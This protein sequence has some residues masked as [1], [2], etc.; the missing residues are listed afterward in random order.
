MITTHTE[1]IVI[2]VQSCFKSN[3]GMSVACNIIEVMI[4]IVNNVMDTR[5]FIKLC[6]RPRRSLFLT[7]M[8]KH[9]WK[10]KG[11]PQED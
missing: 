9:L 3:K 10:A 6:F 1:L 7:I 11:V 2:Q 8:K 5:K 4:L